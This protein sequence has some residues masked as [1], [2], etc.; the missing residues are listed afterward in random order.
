M[1][2]PLPGDA[3]LEVNGPLNNKTSNIEDC[4][5]PEFF[6]DNVQITDDDQ[7]IELANQCVQSSSKTNNGDDCSTHDLGVEKPL[8]G[9]ALVPSK[10]NSSDDC[11]KYDLNVYRSLPG[12]ASNSLEIN[13]SFHCSK[14]SSSDISTVQGNAQSLFAEYQHQ[15][16]YYVVPTVHSSSDD[17][18]SSFY[19][20]DKNSL[21]GHGELR[22]NNEGSTITVGSEH[23]VLCQVEATI[24]RLPR[25]SNH[26]LSPVGS[27]VSSEDEIHIIMELD[28]EKL[29]HHFD[30]EPPD[31]TT[32]IA[33]E[34]SHHTVGSLVDASTDYSTALSECSSGELRE[35]GSE[36]DCS[37]ASSGSEH[38]DCV[39]DYDNHMSETKPSS[40][41]S[42]TKISSDGPLDSNH[43]LRCHSTLTPR[44]IPGQLSVTEGEQRTQEI[45]QSSD[46]EETSP[47]PELS[48]AQGVHSDHQLLSPVGSVISTDNDVCI[49]MELDEEELP[50]RFDTIIAIATENS[51]HTVGSLVDTSTDYSTA[52]SEC[53][54]GGLREMGSE[55][56]HSAASS[57]SEHKDYV[58]DCAQLD[59]KEVD[60]TSTRA[61]SSASLSKGSL[62]RSCLGDSENSLNTCLRCHSTI[63]PCT[64]LGRFCVSNV[65]EEELHEDFTQSTLCEGISSHLE[66]SADQS[67]ATGHQL[68]PVGSIVSTDDETRI[69]M[70][71]DEK[72]SPI[73]GS[74][75][76]DTSTEYYTALSQLSSGQLSGG[77]NHSA[78][79]RHSEPVMISSG[80]E[81]IDYVQ[82]DMEPL[83]S[84]ANLLKMSSSASLFI[85]RGFSNGPLPDNDSSLSLASFQRNDST[86]TFHSILGQLSGSSAS[87]GEQEQ[88]HHDPLPNQTPPIYEPY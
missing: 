49:V 19:F 87:E 50:H 85:P 64:I 28:E 1:D 70:E 18:S 33:T 56:N 71:L 51:H 4:I 58:Q 83:G 8:L 12:D 29:P 57:G 17:S 21:P 53:S 5:S 48:A 78:A 9:D 37:A 31:T 39:Q 6:Q 26:Q 44:N 27:V 73:S 88:R 30:Q 84:K 7:Q 13:G 80:S 11:S 2:K 61:N 74:E 36:S 60:D 72:E 45:T 38:R 15:H 52:V 77:S 76:S 23:Q 10:S 34:N 14:A 3:S 69:V 59:M 67:S 68:S 54:S 25:F 42:V 40:F 63:T 66:A 62:D 20:S 47:F 75:I 16:P 86:T 35:M 55:S 24:Q 79:A 43:S 41:S 32:A 82:V 46:C 22:S 65:S 81:S